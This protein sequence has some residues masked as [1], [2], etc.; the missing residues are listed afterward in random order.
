[1]SRKETIKNKLLERAKY[2]QNFVNKS[3]FPSKAIRSL[4]D[5]LFLSE[6]TIMRDMELD[7]VDSKR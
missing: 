1:M 4:A 2:I 7:T 6:K 3:Q 5:K